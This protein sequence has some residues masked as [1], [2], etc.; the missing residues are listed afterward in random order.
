[1]KSKTFQR[2]L[3]YLKPYTPLLVCTFLL[4]TVCVA[5]QLAVPYFVGKA[6]DCAVGYASILKDFT[7]CL[8]SL[9]HAWRRSSHRSF[10]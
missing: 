5:G 2:I 3:R 4:A 10:F 6:I 9:R 7:S 1:M 8:S